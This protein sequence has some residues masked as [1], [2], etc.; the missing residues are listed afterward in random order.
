VFVAV[1]EATIN[2]DAASLKRGVVAARKQGLDPK[3]VI[4]PVRTE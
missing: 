1:H 2:M 3:V 4:N